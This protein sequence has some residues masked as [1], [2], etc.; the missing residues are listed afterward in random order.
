MT[1]YHDIILKI[2]EELSDREKIYLTMT[3]K[4]MDKF[5]YK[6]R[7]REKICV[8]EIANLSYFD[9]FECI[10]LSKPTSRCPKFA[11]YIYFVADMTNIPPM[12]THLRF[13]YVFNE[14]IKKCIP[15]SVTHLKFNFWFNQPIEDDDIP[16]SVT[17][18]EFGDLFNQPIRNKI[19]ASVIYLKFGYSFYHPINNYI[20]L[21]VTE[22]VFET[23][24]DLIID[25]AILS[26]T[27]ITRY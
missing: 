7:Y 4:W 14:Q 16:V 5:K 18:L 13:F 9:N 3:S 6:C 10:R 2:C 20:P 15:G 8:D 25:E 12:V 27:K 21:S 23:D 1:L 17:H 26:R 24:Y 11:K 19:P 22:I